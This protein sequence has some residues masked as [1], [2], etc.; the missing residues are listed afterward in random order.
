MKKSI[1]TTLPFETTKIPNCKLRYLFEIKPGRI[2]IF[3]LIK[4]TE[5]VENKD[6]LYELVIYGQTKLV[7]LPWIINFTYQPLFNAESFA[8]KW[9]VGYRDGDEMNIHPNNLFWIT[10]DG[11]TECPE[12]KGFFV[13]C[14]YSKHA[15]NKEGEVYSRNTD[16]LQLVRS[17]RPSLKNSYWNCNLT[18]DGRRENQPIGTVGVHR[19]IML[20]FYRIS[21]NPDKI[22]ANHKD[23]NKWN[24]KLSNIEPMTY[25][26]NN[27]HARNSGLHS[28]GEIRGDK[29]N[30]DSRSEF[31]IV[32]RDYKDMKDIAFL[33]ISDCVLFSGFSR[34]IVET[35][36]CR[37]VKNI[38]SSKLFGN[39]YRFFFD[40]E[41]IPKEPKFERINKGKIRLDCIA[42]NV[43][44]KEMVFAE[45]HYELAREIKQKPARVLAGLVK[46][47]KVP[48]NGYIYARV[49]DGSSLM[50]EYEEDL[51]EFY[52]KNPR[53]M[54]PLKVSITKNDVET[55]AYYP[56]VDAAYENLR[57]YVSSR[58]AMDHRL[59]K[60]PESTFVKDGVIIHLKKLWL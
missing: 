6:D 28:Y 4:D 18:A 51:L 24:N 44:T 33:S 1:E 8:F 12:K 56:S 27:H 13:I 34:K 35:Y 3:D 42:M 2:R 39:R 58:K 37:D 11:G 26:E 22:T 55:T 21:V 16:K 43:F 23:G 36:L 40:N 25:T 19:A 46:Q 29:R 45:N 48:Y 52:K 15:V 50:I 32:M 7:S 9:S 38:E 31:G 54:F 53:T 60:V 59:E 49:G 41:Q 14:G 57:E 17:T 47:T 30:H 10:E 20:A 5:V